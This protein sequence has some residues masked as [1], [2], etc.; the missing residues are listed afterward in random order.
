MRFLLI[1]IACLA[2]STSFAKSKKS[3]QLEIGQIPPSYLG[4]EKKLFVEGYKGK[5][6]IVTFWASWYSPCRKE[7]PILERIQT[8]LGEG[9]IKVIAII[10]KESSKKY[11]A[12]RRKL[13]DHNFKL[14][15]DRFDSIAKTYGAKTIPDLFIIDKT[16]KLAYH[17]VGYG[18]KSVDKIVA[19]INKYL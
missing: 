19:V 11:R 14:S 13:K 4:K 10:L 7:L 3:P 12:I 18:D 5:L 8:K 6:I 2:I 9:K 16:S 17:A 15:R 1:L